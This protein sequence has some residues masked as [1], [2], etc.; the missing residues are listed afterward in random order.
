ML[1]RNAIGFPCGSQNHSTCCNQKC[2]WRPKCINNSMKKVKPQTNILYDS[3]YMLFWKRKGYRDKKRIS[4]CA[5]TRDGGRGDY[6][7]AWENYGKWWKLLASWLQWCL[8]NCTFVKTQ[9]SNSHLKHS[10]R[11]FPGAV[12]WLR[13]YVSKGRGTGSIPGQRKLTH[14][15]RQKNFK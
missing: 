15:C 1:Y 4:G 7:V 8:H 14:V 2:I 10:Y 12:K 11:D 6:K 3:I 13:T 5:R 9:N